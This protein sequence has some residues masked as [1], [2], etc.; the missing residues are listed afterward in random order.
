MMMSPVGQ[1]ALQGSKSLCSRFARL[2][3][4]SRCRL[5]PK[6]PRLTDKHDESISKLKPKKSKTP[7]GAYDIADEERSR[8]R[9]KEVHF[10]RTRLTLL[11]KLMTSTSYEINYIFFFISFVTA[12]TCCWMVDFWFSAKKGLSDVSHRA[13]KREITVKWRNSLEKM[14]LQNSSR[15]W[16]G[17]MGTK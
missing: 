17:R 12:C 2:I 1:K 3:R 6:M 11:T 9:S 8:G 15:W 4:A 5:G 7:N 13:N 14:T 16:L 10:K